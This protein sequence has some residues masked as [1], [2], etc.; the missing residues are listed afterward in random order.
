MATEVAPPPSATPPAAAPPP[1]LKH[2]YIGILG[3]FLG[4]SVA[5][6]NA[7]LLSIGLPDL[8]GALGLGFDEA[9]C[10]PR[11]SIWQ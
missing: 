10:C 2:P 9:S 4:A 3:V 5:T 11:S 1:L 7:R 8:R 6:V